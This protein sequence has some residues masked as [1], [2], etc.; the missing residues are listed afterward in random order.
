MSLA[1][2]SLPPLTPAFQPSCPWLDRCTR[3]L[4]TD[5]CSTCR[6]NPGACDFDGGQPDPIAGL[7]LIAIGFAEAA[8]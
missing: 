7:H 1:S 5:G 6:F 2:L 3:T 4:L 8:R